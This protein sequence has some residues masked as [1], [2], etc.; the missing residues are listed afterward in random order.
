MYKYSVPL[1]YV[2]IYLLRQEKL[3][4]NSTL[5]DTQLQM[6]DRGN[7]CNCG[8][9]LLY[10]FFYYLPPKHFD[11]RGIKYPLLQESKHCK[12]LE[13]V[14]PKSSRTA[15]KRAEPSKYHHP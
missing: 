14:A 9:F 13:K 15:K 11:M 6:S 12:N 1:F 7:K 4:N 3:V 2:P 10:Y 8:C 5:V